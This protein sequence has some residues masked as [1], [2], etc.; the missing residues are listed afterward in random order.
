MAVRGQTLYSLCSYYS[1]NAAMSLGPVESK[2]E[3]LLGLGYLTA[4]YKM[5][6]LLRSESLSSLHHL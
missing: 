5:V 4:I 2:I 3:W 1:G 6:Q